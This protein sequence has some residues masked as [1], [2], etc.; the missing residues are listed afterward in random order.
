MRAVGQGAVV[1]IYLLVAVVGG[2]LILIAPLLMV[3]GAEDSTEMGGLVGI[4]V[5]FLFIGAMLTLGTVDAGLIV[6]EWGT[7]PSAGG[8][9]PWDDSEWS[10]DV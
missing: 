10:S 2:L 4:G 7:A 1:A 9:D 6:D 5:V 3:V 8:R